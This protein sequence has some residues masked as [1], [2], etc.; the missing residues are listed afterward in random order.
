MVR[1]GELG[2]VL[3]VSRTVAWQFAKRPDFPSPIVL[4]DRLRMW[5]REEVIAWRDAHQKENPE[6]ARPGVHVQHDQSRGANAAP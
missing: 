5:K 1:A 6:P 2:G 4:S 3:G